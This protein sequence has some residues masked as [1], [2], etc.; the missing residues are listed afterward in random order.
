MVSKGGHGVKL[1]SDGTIITS[2]TYLAY[3]PPLFC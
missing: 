1:G 2:P 3:L